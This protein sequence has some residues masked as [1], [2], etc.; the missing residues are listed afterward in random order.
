MTNETTTTRTV[1]DMT[2]YYTDNETL[3]IE[4]E[5]DKIN[6]FLT[7]IG[8][9]RLYY[10]QAM[11]SGVYIPTSS[12]RYVKAD[13]RVIQVQQPATST[14]TTTTTETV[15][16]TPKKTTTSRTTKP[17]RKRRTKAEM[18]AARAA[19]AST[20]RRGRKAKSDIAVAA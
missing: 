3:T 12:I 15:A 11:K 10:N 9:G 4:I 20:K 19:V 16:A 17:R 7:A 5:N 18:E 6:E 1:V 13:E 2:V 8:T 14:T